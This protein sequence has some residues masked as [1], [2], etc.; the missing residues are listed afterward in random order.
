MVSPDDVLSAIR[1]AEK[2]W[3]GLNNAWNRVKRDQLQA[4]ET[5]L[6]EAIPSLEAF[7]NAV[8]TKDWPAIKMQAEK[9]SGLL[10]SVV[11]ALNDANIDSESVEKLETVVKTAGLWEEYFPDNKDK[12]QKVS[13]DLVDA[14]KK[15][16]AT[17]KEKLSSAK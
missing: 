17:A 3:S 12:Y 15:L 11:D 10:K 14:L 16:H 13:P 9:T 1:L 6:R 5:A 8:P 2:A 4:I 7:N